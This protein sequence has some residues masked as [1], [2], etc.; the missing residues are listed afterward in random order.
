MEPIGVSSTPVQDYE[1]LVRSANE[2]LRQRDVE[3]ARTLFRQSADARPSD[4]RAWYG[5]A[6]A[7]RSLGD[8]V[9]QVTSLDRLLEAN[10]NHVGGLI[11]KADHF[12][13]TG[14]GRAAHSFYEAALARAGPDL[15]FELRAEVQRAR[16]E[17]QRYAR[18]YE[19]HLRDALADAGYDKAR[20]SPRFGRCL[21]MLFG[22]SQIFLQS[23]TA[24]YFPEL[25]QR[26]FYERA[27]FPWLAA[28]E[29]RTDVI[30]EE[31]VGVLADEA[32]IFS[33]YVQSVGNRP[34]RDYGDLLDN[35][36]WSA[37][38]LVRS[39][40]VVE[41]AAQRCP[42]TLK[43]LGDAPL[44]DA[45]GRTPSVLFSLLRPGVRIPPHT[46]Y[47]NARL[48]C[49]LPLIV[50]EGCGLRVGNETRGWTEGEALIFDDSI[51]HEAWNSSA[52]PR[53]VLLFDIWRPEMTDEE[54]KLVAATLAAVG[55][56]GNLP[57]WD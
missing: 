25:P 32:R 33:P 23:P 39:G 19:G 18:S 49:H 3:T 45:P 27:E 57:A 8:D 34:R 5:L 16:Q 15:P 26:Q 20:S 42:G 41:E 10:P 55:S 43:A 47:T 29:A 17:S 9:G 28:L 11:M 13:R 6:Q 14:D 40:E 38:Y 35:P 52:K 56:Y 31:L 21:D 53:V 54:R 2:A 37:F 51:E 30:R 46:G 44:T 12:A 48:I 7:C 24:F 36:G 4:A 1:G 22:R 50:P